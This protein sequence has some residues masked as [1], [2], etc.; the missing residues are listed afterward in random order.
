MKTSKNR[1]EWFDRA[2][3]LDKSLEDAD[4]FSSYMSLSL[5][6]GA[7]LTLASKEKILA[8][9]VTGEG[10]AGCWAHRVVPGSAW[11]DLKVG[12]VVHFKSEKVEHHEIDD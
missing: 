10:N 2:I 3:G 11:Y 6:V 5:E 7:S 12:D 1:Y 4:K 9:R 8:L